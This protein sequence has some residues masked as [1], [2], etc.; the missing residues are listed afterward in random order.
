MNRMTK[1]CD[2]RDKWGKNNVTV[3]C[4]IINTDFCWCST[5]PTLYIRTYYYFIKRNTIV[6][7]LGE[8]KNIHCNYIFVTRVTVTKKVQFAI[9]VQMERVK[10][11][12][13]IF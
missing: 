9:F 6:S 7:E 12:I 2:S 8:E 11:E 10:K 3:G 1:K 4:C 5:H 13:V